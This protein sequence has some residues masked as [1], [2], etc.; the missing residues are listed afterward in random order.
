VVRTVPSTVVT[1]RRQPHTG[2]AVDR[3]T[4]LRS[5]LGLG[6]LAV[7]GSLLAAC[8]D[9]SAD[10]TR[11]ADGQVPKNALIAAFPQG[12][13]HVATGVPTRLPYLLADKEGVPLSRIDGPVTFTVEQDGKAVGGPVQV[14]P[15]SDGVPRAYLPLSFT[16]PQAGVYDVFADYGGQKLDSTLQVYGAD[17][18]GPP[19]VGEALP[20]AETATAANP[21]VDPVCSRV[22]PCPFHEVNLADAVGQGKPIVLM[23]AT[24]AYCQTAVCGPILDTLV[25]QASGRTDITVIHSEVYRNPKEVRDIQDANLAP[26]PDTYDLRFEPAMFVTNAAGTIVA[27][28][29]VTVDRTEMTELLALAK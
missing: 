26:V 10:G 19:V 25:D 4:V 20:P 14:A 22:P 16:F 17:Q 15:R 9:D 24:P 11:V 21:L 7:G 5:G 27:R 6:A 13:P 3:R 8:G 29:D 12:V 2:S 28:A 18:I 23:V 1:I